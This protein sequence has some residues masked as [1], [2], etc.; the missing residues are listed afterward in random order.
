M[1]KS[2]AVILVIYRSVHLPDLLG[3][4]LRKRQILNF[5]YARICVYYSPVRVVLSL[6]FCEKS[7]FIA[8]YGRFDCVQNSAHVTS[9]KLLSLPL[10]T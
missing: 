3:P 4:Y 6:K 9:R 7:D 10:A 8:D 2:I 1:T 5:K